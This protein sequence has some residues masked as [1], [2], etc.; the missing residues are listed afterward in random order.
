MIGTR[1][2]GAAAL[3][4]SLALG[5]PAG[6]AQ[7]SAPAPA[8]Q[9][10]PA[11]TP[12]AKA[13]AKAVRKRPTQEER[14]EA[15]IKALHAELKITPD[16]EQ[17]WGAVAQVMRDSARNIDELSQKRTTDRSKMS[18][19]DNLRSYQA[20]ADAHADEMNKLVPAF[21][22]LYDKMSDA[23]KKNADMVFNHRQARRTHH[24]PAT[25]KG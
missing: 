3:A 18:A 19:V 21:S 12:A 2:L 13:P 25:K 1:F 8:P 16:Q 6:V 22:A 23:Q 14:V 11:P 4:A 17:E 5:A 9:A 15:R 20:I 10:T 7:Q 24:A